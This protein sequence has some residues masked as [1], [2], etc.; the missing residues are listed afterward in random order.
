[1]GNSDLMPGSYQTPPNFN[2]FNVVKLNLHCQSLNQDLKCE[3]KIL[4]PITHKTKVTRRGALSP[5]AASKLH[6]DHSPLKTRYLYS[7]KV[8]LCQK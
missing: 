6:F 2:H 8:I 7:S 4:I 1:M 5:P 3:L